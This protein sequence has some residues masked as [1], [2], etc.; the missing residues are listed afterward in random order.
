MFLPGERV[1]VAVSGGADSMCMLSLLL[2][3]REMFGIELRAA[4]VHHGIRGE[5]ADEDAAFVEAFCKA[6]GIPFTLL[7]VNV[8]IEAAKTGES[9]ELCARRLRYDALLA[10]PADKVATAHTASDAAETLLM[11]LSR[12]SGLTG[13]CAIPPVRE[14][15]VRPLIECFR[16]ETES[17]CTEHGVPFVADSTNALDCCTR[18]RI[19]HHVIP[20]LREIFPAFETSV[21]RCVRLLRADADCLDQQAYSLLE[22][23]ADDAARTLD[24]AALVDAPA[25]LRRRALAAFIAR[26]S[27]SDYEARHIELLDAHLSSASFALTLPSGVCIRL[28]NGLLRFDDYSAGP[29]PPEIRM[30]TAEGGIFRFGDFALR[31]RIFDGAP[32]EGKDVFY[33]DMS[34]IDNEMILRARRSGDRITFAA[35]GCSKT[36]KKYYNEIGLPVRERDRMPVLADSRGVIFAVPAGMDAARLPD[37]ETK[38]YL[39]IELFQN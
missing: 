19:R 33:A 12:G 10:L 21:A 23:A 6:R 13:L 5:E 9:E 24:T 17:Y 2:D 7:R 32:P 25:A 15:I 36:L 14:N 34:K 4:H 1:T 35:R 20:A 22:R 39:C 11:N 28:R 18:N 26:Y 29:P 27:G 31:L 8:P 37:A 30:R 16:S 3:C 38:A